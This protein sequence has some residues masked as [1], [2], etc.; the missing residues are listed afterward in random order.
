MSG[1]KASANRPKS[2]KNLKGSAKTKRFKANTEAQ[3]AYHAKIQA[4]RE[5]KRKRGK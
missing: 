2:A 4:R 3:S 1:I 5:K